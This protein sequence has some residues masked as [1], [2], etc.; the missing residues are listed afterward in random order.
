MP[1]T[2]TNDVELIFAVNMN[3]IIFKSHVTRTVANFSGCLLL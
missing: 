2:K 1:G 3:I